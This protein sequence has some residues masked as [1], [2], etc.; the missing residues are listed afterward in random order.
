MVAVRPRFHGH[1]TPT[2]APWLNQVEIW[3]NIVTKRAICRGT[4]RDVRDLVARIE[5]FTRSYNRDCQ[6]FVWTAT[7]DSILAKIE[8]LVKLSLGQHTSSDLRTTGT[9]RRSC[10]GQRN[11]VRQD[12]YDKAA[13]TRVIDRY[14][15]QSWSSSPCTATHTA[16]TGRNVNDLTVSEQFKT[17]QP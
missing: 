5:R 9:G 15:R 13:T 6:P 2:Y 17:R 14:C 10:T 1:Y 16:T 11:Q 3:F 8:R 12:R 4:F 7:A